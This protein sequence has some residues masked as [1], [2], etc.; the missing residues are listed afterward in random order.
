MEATP[1][2]DS[3]SPATVLTTAA[4]ADRATERGDQVMR[5]LSRELGRGER[6]SATD[7]SLADAASWALDKAGAV[8]RSAARQLR[9]RAASAIAA[10]IRAD[11]L[12][13]VLIAAA[14]GALAMSLLSKATKSGART[15]E[16]RVR[17]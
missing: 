9:A 17:S 7:S 10:P 8:L 16:R 11:P 2:K 12:R 1:L 6:S 14:V 5:N 3:H 4:T 15:I 13:A